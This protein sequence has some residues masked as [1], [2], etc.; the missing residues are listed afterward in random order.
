MSFKIYQKRKYPSELL[1][2]DDVQFLNT[3]TKQSE[4]DH[5]LNEIITEAQKEVFLD[6]LKEELKIHYFLIQKDI[7]IN[8]SIIWDVYPNPFFV[9]VGNDFTVIKDYQLVFDINIKYRSVNSELPYTI[10]KFTIMNN[11]T[12]IHQS[13]YGFDAL[14]M[15]ADKIILD[16]K[17]GDTISFSIHTKENQQLFLTKQSFIQIKIM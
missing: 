6:E 17:M 15:I 12:V 1:S 13:N 4:E 11:N 10:V 8:N 9:Q 5:L 3:L 7:A 14:N 2:Y 16:L